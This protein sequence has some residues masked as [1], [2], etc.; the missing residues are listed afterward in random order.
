MRPP[1]V[2]A[3]NMFSK[4]EFFSPPVGQNNVSP[5]LETYSLLEPSS[6]IPLN[7]RPGGAGLSEGALPPNISAL[8]NRS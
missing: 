3:K 1:A 8:S 4:N 7:R 6:T 5:W 2:Q